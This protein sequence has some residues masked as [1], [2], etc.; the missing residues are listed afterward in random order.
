MPVKKLKQFLDDN[1]VPYYTINHFYANTAQK[2]A[3]T[4]HIPGKNLA[5]AVMVKVDGKMVMAVLAWFLPHRYEP[6]K[7]SHG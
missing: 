4:A 1:N 3:A 7:R 6:S 2:I 5:K